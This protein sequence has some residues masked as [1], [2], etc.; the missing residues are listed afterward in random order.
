MLH[1]LSI[2]LTMFCE[3]W[4]LLTF[5]MLLLPLDLRSSALCFQTPSIFGRHLKLTVKQHM[6]WGTNWN[7]RPQ[8][9]TQNK[10]RM[11]NFSNAKQKGSLRHTFDIRLAGDKNRK[12][13][14]D[15]CLI[16]FMQGTEKGLTRTG[17]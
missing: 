9:A 3:K 7:N 6:G 11:Y 12:A 4:E 2:I 10:I 17:V 16:S 5:P 8:L 14:L 15:K 13:N 1:V